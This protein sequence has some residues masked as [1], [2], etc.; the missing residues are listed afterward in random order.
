MLATKVSFQAEEY[1]DLQ[2]GHHAL[3]VKVKHY[4]MKLMHDRD[5]CALA[6]MFPNGDGQGEP[7]S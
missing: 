5:I 7:L 1:N 4:I 6:I 3:V 2:I